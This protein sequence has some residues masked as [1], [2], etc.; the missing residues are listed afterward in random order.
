MTI[1]ATKFEENKAY[2]ASTIYF[3]RSNKK[4]IITNSEFVKNDGRGLMEVLSSHLEM[5][6]T[7]VEGNISEESPNIKAIVS[8]IKMFNNTFSDQECDRACYFLI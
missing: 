1:E 2:T 6:N 3:S 8:I 5:N 4:S 7:V